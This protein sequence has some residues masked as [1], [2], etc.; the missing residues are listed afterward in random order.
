MVYVFSPQ[1]KE[2][3]RDIF[4][5]RKKTFSASVRVAA[6][7][8]LLTQDPQ[9]TDVRDVILRIAKEKPEVSKFL[10]ARIMSLL[11]SDNPAR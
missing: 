3:I 4:T 9:H 8:I 11:H 6:A 2:H 7:Q 5:Q 10:S 1:V